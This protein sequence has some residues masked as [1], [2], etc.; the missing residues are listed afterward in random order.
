MLRGIAK[1]ISL[2]SAMR[3]AVTLKASPHLFTIGSPELPRLLYFFF[4]QAEDGIRDKLVTGVQTCALTIWRRASLLDS[5]LTELLGMVFWSSV[6]LGTGLI[7]LLAGQ[8]IR[9]GSFTVGDFAL[10][11]FYLSLV[12]EAMTTIG[13]FSARI[14]QAGVSVQRLVELLAGGGPQRVLEG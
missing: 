2:A 10:F 11:V 12:T 14:R 9:T 5:L 3:A 8:S 7:L 1:L 6:N 13:N 4:F